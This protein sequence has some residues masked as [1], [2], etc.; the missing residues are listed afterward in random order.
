MLAS[1]IATATIVISREIKVNLLAS[2]LAI[3]RAERVVFP[4]ALAMPSK[5]YH[6]TKAQSHSAAIS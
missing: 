3:P 2:W 5:R 1:W 6:L 4:T